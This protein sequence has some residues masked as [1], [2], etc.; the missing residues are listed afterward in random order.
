MKKIFCAAIILAAAYTVSAQEVVTT[1]KQL[2]ASLII[3]H[4]YQ[5]TI[6]YKLR[7]QVILPQLQ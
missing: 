7:R 2:T 6:K 3:V 4:K 1:I 5:L